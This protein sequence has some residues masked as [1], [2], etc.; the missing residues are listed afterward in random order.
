MA[1]QIS[2][3]RGKMCEVDGTGN[4][5]LWWEHE[6]NLSCYRGARCAASTTSM[7]AR[8]HGNRHGSS[9]KQAQ[10]SHS[11]WSPMAAGS[12]EG[13]EVCSPRDGERLPAE[14]SGSCV[15][16]AG[17]HHKRSR[18]VRDVVCPFY[19]TTAAMPPAPKSASLLIAPPTRGMSSCGGDGSYSG[20]PQ[21]TQQG[22]WTQ[23]LMAKV[24]RFLHRGRSVGTGSAKRKVTNSDDH[25]DQKDGTL[26]RK[27]Q[28]KPQADYRAPACLFADRVESFHRHLDKP[29]VEHFMSMFCERTFARENLDFVRQVRAPPTAVAADGMKGSGPRV[30]CGTYLSH[31]LVWVSV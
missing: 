22:R 17:S 4:I 8:S 3:L 12:Q 1:A 30:D 28:C 19:C 15:Q 23:K 13:T 11:L 9:G 27:A 25:F 6:L 7:Q 2:A 14:L 29:V 24:S 20:S 5:I 18:S 26:L 31:G 16:Q 21:S 10:E